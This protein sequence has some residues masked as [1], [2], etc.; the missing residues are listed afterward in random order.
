MAIDK[1]ALR[2]YVEREISNIN[3]MFVGIIEK[4]DVANMKY[5][6][7]PSETVLELNFR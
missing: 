5:N 2:R 7:K 4:V 1:T 3:T 6:V